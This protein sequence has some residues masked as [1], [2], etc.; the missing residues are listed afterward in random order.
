MNEPNG[1]RDPRYDIL[2]E[3]VRIGPKVARNRFFQ[4]PHCNGMGFRHPSALARMRGV[5]AEGGWAVVC[6]EEVEIHPSGEIAPFIEGRLWS[7]ADIPAL[8]RMT[9]AV[10][11]EGA[12]AGIELCHNGANAPNLYS[13]EPPLGP[14]HAPVATFSYEPVQARRM[15]RSDIAA[16][17]R[18]HRAAARRSL[19]AGFDVVYVYAAHALSFLSHFLSRSLND[20]TDE[21]GGCLANRARLLRETLE[22]TI[23]EISGR[24]AVGCRI[25]MAE[26][27]VPLGLEQAEAEDTIGMLAELPDFWD[28]AL[29]AWDSDSPTSRFAE[30]GHEEPFIRNVKSLTS[31]PVVGVGRYTSPDRMAAIVR[32]GLVD[33]VG[34]ARPSIADPFLPRKVEEGRIEDIRECIGCNICVSGDFTMTPI[35]CTQNPS[36]GEEWRRGWHPERIRPR[37]SDKSVLVVGGGPAGLEAA[38]SL[39]RRGY[40]VTLAE[41]GESLGGRVSRESRLPGLATWARV[42]DYRTTQ[43]SRMPNVATYF[44]SRVDAEGA[45][46]FGFPRIVAATGARWRRDAVGHTHRRRPPMDP[47]AVALTPDDLMDAELPEAGSRTLVWD[48]DHYYMAGALSELLI[49]HGCEVVYATPACEASTWTRATMEQH[50]IHTRLLEKG[51]EVRTFRTLAR[52][53]VDAAMLACTF[54]GREERVPVDATVLVTSRLPEESLVLDLRARE[55]DWAGAGVESVEA[56]GDALYPAT[57]AHAVHGGRRYAEDLDAPPSPDGAVPFRMEITALSPH[58]P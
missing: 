49:D 25:S 1:R 15:D 39:G 54:T 58:W 55:G 30:E 42:R 43:I 28:V 8:A 56:I 6:T 45:L 29:A 36:M 51:V 13:R 3:P 26:I 48:D 14:T 40:E 23:E 37:E 20:R 46:S 4:V 53:E 24:A 9:E 21:Y 10:Q 7:D 11:A 47:R 5:K 52:L 34:A 32:K 31:K 16:V 35:R 50:R 12:L 44:G 33:F 18:W 2:F 57:I 19:T 27:G 38:M 41:A 22:D 17:R